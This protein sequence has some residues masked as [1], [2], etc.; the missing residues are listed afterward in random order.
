MR[1]S[2][3]FLTLHCAPHML[4]SYCPQS[5]ILTRFFQLLFH[6][7]FHGGHNT[8]RGRLFYWMLSWVAYVQLLAIPCHPSIQWA[9]P[10]SW[11]Q[12]AIYGLHVPV[13]DPDVV[14]PDSPAMLIVFW[15]L[16]S[17]HSLAI[18]IIVAIYNMSQIMTEKM[19]VGGLG[20]G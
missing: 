7:P 4:L 19:Q 14:S 5:M 15:A 1:L 3:R 6:F 11:L 10:I 9:P 18:V 20:S 17:V 12:S 13:W 8:F 2:P 16:F